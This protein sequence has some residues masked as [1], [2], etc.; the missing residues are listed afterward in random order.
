MTYITRKNTSNLWPISQKGTKYVIVPSHN[1]KNGIPLLIVMRDILKLV[2]TRK[3]LKKILL[4][5]KILVN[6]KVAKEENLS[7]VLYIAYP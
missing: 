5:K 3:E 2:K 7:M 1:R 6:N 4:E